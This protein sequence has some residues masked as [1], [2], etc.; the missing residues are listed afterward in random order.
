[1]GSVALSRLE[2]CVLPCKA[3][4]RGVRLK[5]SDR[6]G[7]EIADGASVKENIHNINV[8]ERI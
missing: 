5:G 7:C 8:M 1:M 4:V 3:C 6:L 2:K